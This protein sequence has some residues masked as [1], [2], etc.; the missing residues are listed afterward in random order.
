MPEIDSQLFFHDLPTGKNTG[1]CESL[2]GS[3]DNGSV[4]H[5]YD[6]CINCTVG[7]CMMF[8]CLYDEDG[9]TQGRRFTPHDPLY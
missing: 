9:Q 1:L 6:D 5:L 8:V 4:V 7:Q 2:G 3:T